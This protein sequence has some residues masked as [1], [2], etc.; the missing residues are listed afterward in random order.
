MVCKL[1]RDLFGL[2]PNIDFAF[3]VLRRALG[4]PPQAG[5][6]I[7][8]AG[9]MVGWVAHALEQYAAHEQI[10]PRAIYT[11]ERPRD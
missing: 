4:L 1:A 5:K 10:R 7:F 9:R 8:C 11:G 3:A 2:E 6:T